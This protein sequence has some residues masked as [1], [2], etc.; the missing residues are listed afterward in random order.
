MEIKIKKIGNA[1]GTV[2]W[3]IRGLEDG[4]LTLVESS[5]RS[6]S[7]W[8]RS[9]DGLVDQIIAVLGDEY[10][11]VAI[12]MVVTNACRG[13]L[14]TIARAWCEERA[15]IETESESELDIKIARGLLV[16]SPA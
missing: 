14:N 3:L 12:E 10:E 1:R 11:P 6:H 13:A 7:L 5:I 8:L 2:A 9:G 16:F 4:S 15:R